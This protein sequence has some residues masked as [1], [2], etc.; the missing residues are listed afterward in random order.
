[1]V[2]YAKTTGNYLPLL[3]VFVVTTSLYCS[4]P[5]MQPEKSMASPSVIT[6]CMAIVQNK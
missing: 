5:V 6:T 1:M 2:F 3:G 4:F